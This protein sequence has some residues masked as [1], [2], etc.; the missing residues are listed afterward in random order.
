MPLRLLWHFYFILSTIEMCL[1][2]AGNLE[3]PVSSISHSSLE[4]DIIHMFPEPLY[5]NRS[6]AALLSVRRFP[7]N[8]SNKSFICVVEKLTDSY[9]D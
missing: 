4:N 7:L 2:I 6:T 3:A 9:E 1:A 5:S 8:S